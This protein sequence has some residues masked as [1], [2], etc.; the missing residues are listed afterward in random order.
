MTTEKQRR[1]FGLVNAGYKRI[2]KPKKQTHGNLLIDGIVK[3]YNLP[4]ALLQFKKREL[5]H[6]GVSPRRIKISYCR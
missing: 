1:E 4:F 2:E 3:D 5:I 6:N